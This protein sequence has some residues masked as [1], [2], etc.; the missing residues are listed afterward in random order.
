VPVKP[1]NTE[2]EFFVRED[3]EKK[4]KLALDQAKELEARERE[5]LK[6][7]HWMRCPKCGFELTT[8]SFKGVDIDKCFHCGATVFDAGELEKIGVKEKEGVVKALV[9]VFNK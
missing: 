2:E 5:D 9:R 7:L 1:S 8:V 3:A 4:R 6:K